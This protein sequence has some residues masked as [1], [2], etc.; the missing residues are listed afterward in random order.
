MTGKA[1]GSSI[2]SSR[3]AILGQSIIFIHKENP[4][5]F[6]SNH[7]NGSKIFCLL[8]HVKQSKAKLIIGLFVARG[9]KAD[10]SNYLNHCR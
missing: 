1:V 8:L 3:D 4:Y 6:K 9:H 7:I 10:L 2:I 5:R